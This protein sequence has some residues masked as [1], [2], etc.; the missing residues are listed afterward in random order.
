MLSIRLRSSSKK[1]KS[2]TLKTPLLLPVPQTIN[3]LIQLRRP[4]SHRGPSRKGTARLRHI[5]TSCCYGYHDAVRLLGGLGNLIVDIYENK[6]AYISTSIIQAGREEGGYTCCSLLDVLNSVVDG[7]LSGIEVTLLTRFCA[8]GV[9]DLLGDG[10][11]TLCIWSILANGVK[12][13]GNEECTWLDGTS[14][15]VTC[16]MSVILK[17]KVEFTKLVTHQ[18]W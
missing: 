2:C 5:D 11:I 7:L 12:I 13:C 16:T 1:R 6:K 8:R 10:L 14:Y 18:H 9:G 17:L 4:C 3:Q 15:L